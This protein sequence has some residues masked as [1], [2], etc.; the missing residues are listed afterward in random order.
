MLDTGSNCDVIS[1]DI[2]NARKII[3]TTRNLAVHTVD[4]SIKQDRKLVNLRLKSLDGQ[5]A[6]IVN[7]ALV[8]KL[9]TSSSD[10][11]PA[12]RDTSVYNYL[13][14]I[15]FIDIDAEVQFIVSATHS[16]TW[17]AVPYR[18]GTSRQPLALKTSFGWTLIGN[19]GGPRSNEISCNAIS[20]DDLELRD[21]FQ[22]I[23]YQDFPDLVNEDEMG[24]SEDNRKAVKIVKNS[25]HFNKTIGKYQVA[26]PWRHGRAE[27]KRVLGSV[28]SKSMATRR[29]KGMIPRMRRDEAR[30]ERVFCN[31]EKF[32]S[33]GFA[34]V[35]PPLE[36]DKPVE[37]PLWYLPIHVVEKKGKTRPC[38]D[39]RASVRGILLNDQ[40]LGGPNLIK[41]LHHVLLNFRTKKVA[42]MCDIA[43]FFHHVRLPT[44]TSTLSGT[45]GSR[46]AT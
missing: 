46:T 35:I 40:M 33:S 2:V 39:A 25:I 26:L 13:R 4:H 43:A 12:K 3:T 14:G 44:K 9:L 24:I 37:G 17:L 18:R 36:V 6:V 42:F 34:E 41:S 19:A 7:E 30:K 28:D 16:H 29:L 20:T 1:E 15:D 21:A 22:D 23:F 31:M 45:Y 11:P 8:G 5:Y 38:H 27:A 10:I 32:L